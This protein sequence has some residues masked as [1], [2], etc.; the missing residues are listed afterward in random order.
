MGNCMT[1]NQGQPARPGQFS[2]F[3]RQTSVI[4]KQEVTQE[5]YPSIEDVLTGKTRRRTGKENTR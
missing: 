2:K 4:P 3:Q 1:N 5:P